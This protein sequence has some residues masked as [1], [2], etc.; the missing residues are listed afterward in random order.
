M[1]PFAHPMREIRSRL[2]GLEVSE[3]FEREAIGL[4]RLPG[5]NVAHWLST[6]KLCLVQHTPST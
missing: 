4:T 6:A 5:A 3:E 1:L 2:M